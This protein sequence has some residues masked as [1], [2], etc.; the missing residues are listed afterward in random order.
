[1]ILPSEEIIRILPRD[2]GFADD[3]VTGRTKAAYCP[4]SHRSLAGRLIHHARELTHQHRS[5][6]CTPD[7]AQDAG[8]LRHQFSAIA[9]TQPCHGAGRIRVHRVKPVRALPQA[10]RNEEEPPCRGTQCGS[11]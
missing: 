10:A 4:G 8:P 1:M 9:G 5:A 2:G 11:Y 3:A 7:S 6:D